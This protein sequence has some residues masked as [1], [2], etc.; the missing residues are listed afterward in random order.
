MVTQIL[1]PTV[2]DL[3]HSFSKLLIGTTR[4]PLAAVLATYFVLAIMLELMLYYFVRAKPSFELMWFFMVH[5][6][7]LAN[8]KLG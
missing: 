5:G 7:C 8:R 2:Y 6:I 1:H 4:G 3:V